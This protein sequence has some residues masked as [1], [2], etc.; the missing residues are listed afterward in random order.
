MKKIYSTANLAIIG[1]AIFLFSCFIRTPQTFI[2]CKEAQ[3][4]EAE[5][6]VKRAAWETARL[7]DPATGRIPAGMREKELGFAAN[8]P[9]MQSNSAIARMSNTSFSYRGP[10]NMGGRTRAFA[11]DINNENIVL[12]GSVNGG[13][14]RSTD[15][16][17]TWTR[18][19]PMNT[20]PAVTWV[21]QDKRTGHTNTWYYSTGEIVGAS[22][23]GAYAY[24][25]GNGIWKSNDNGITWSQL[26]ATSSNTP[27]VFDNVW[28][29]I[30]KVVTDPSV[31]TSEVAY[32]ATYGAIYRTAN[33]GTSW[34]KVIGSTSAYS[35]FTDVDVTTTGI[36]YAY[37][38]SDGATKGIY[39]RETTGVLT[40]INP[41]GW[42]TGT[43]NRVVI[44]I[45]PSNENEVYFLG[46]TP[47]MGKQ[48]T[49]YK[50]DIEWT[51]LWKYTYVSGNGSGAGGIWTDLSANIPYTGTQMGNFNSQGG[52]DLIVRVHPAHPNIV[53]IG[54]T[55]LFRSDDGFTTSTMISHIG[56]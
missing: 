14:Y 16:G 31:S 41:P 38:S 52:Y 4:E 9:K 39:R 30:S 43:Y 21:V 17:Q 51:S 27:A 48:T 45:N 35:Y 15:G 11:I 55:N 26:T 5:D 49:N 13:M 50:G 44:G 7:A 46:E 2:E 8:L 40:N 3:S 1:I 22:G 10:V 34:T 6:A 28:D 36:V 32:A 20:D 18:V 37:L 12:A 19:S 29:L 53:Y 33:G 25:L 56:G 54:G 47:N 24:Y 23:S 42:D